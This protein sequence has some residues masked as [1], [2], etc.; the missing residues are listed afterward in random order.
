MDTRSGVASWVRTCWVSPYSTMRRSFKG[1]VPEE[2]V[3]G[4]GMLASQRVRQHSL[5]RCEGLGHF[6]VL[7]DP[8]PCD[9]VLRR[10]QRLPRGI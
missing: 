4:V 8:E 2:S 1:M 5:Q 7:G 3:S 9:E 6:A 10:A